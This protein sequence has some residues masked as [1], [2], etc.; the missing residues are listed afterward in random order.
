MERVSFHSPLQEIFF[1]LCADLDIDGVEKI[2]KWWDIISVRYSEPH[3]KYHTLVHLVEMFT[4][5]E[6]YRNAIDDIWSVSLAVFFHDIIY[7]PT[8]KQNEENSAVLFQDFVADVHAVKLDSLSQKVNDMIIATK[9]HQ[10][11]SLPADIALFLDIDMSILGRDRERYILYA[12][13]IREEYIH[14]DATL[15][16]KSRASFLRST[17]DSPIFSSYFDQKFDIAA[18]DNILWECDILEKGILP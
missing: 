2:M 12:Q 16:C 5:L 3:R 14:I 8:S 15:Y 9:M 11:T 17:V 1:G 6:D 10:S 4:L 13:Q 7:D 18:R